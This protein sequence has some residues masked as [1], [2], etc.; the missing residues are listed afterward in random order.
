MPPWAWKRARILRRRNC[1]ARCRNGISSSRKS[2]AC[3]LPCRN[4]G[5]R[6]LQASD[7]KLALILTFSPW[8]KEE[9]SDAADF[10]TECPTIAIAG[11]RTA[12]EYSPS[13]GGEGRGEDE[14]CHGSRPCRKDFS[15]L[16][17]NQPCAPPAQPAAANYSPVCQDRNRPSQSSRGACRHRR[18]PRAHPRV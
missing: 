12:A 3:S 4:S 2:W 18:N 10:S 5:A 6:I 7:L 8:E 14:P 16:M 11:I 15:A 13:P 1:P 17:L 9:P